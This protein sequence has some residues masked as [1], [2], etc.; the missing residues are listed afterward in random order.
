VHVCMCVGLILY[1]RVCPSAVGATVA[2]PLLATVM[3]CYTQGCRAIDLLKWIMYLPCLPKHPKPTCAPRAHTLP[4]AAS[5]PPA[6]FPPTQSSEQRKMVCTPAHPFY[7]RAWLRR[8]VKHLVR[9]P[10][11]LPPV[12]D[13]RQL[14]HVLHGL[15]MV[16]L[17]QQPGA[18]QPIRCQDQLVGTLRVPLLLEAAEDDRHQ[19]WILLAGEP[20]R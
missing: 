8:A 17:R 20:E 11:Q 16:L 12:L 6:L 2:T 10:L 3:A 18:R 5:S 19:L 15:R 1:L 4:A 13:S 14:L 7:R 9:Q